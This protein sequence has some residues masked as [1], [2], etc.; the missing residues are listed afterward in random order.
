MLIRF[1]S[2]GFPALTTSRV[3]FL[4]DPARYRVCIGIQHMLLGASGGCCCPQPCSDQAILS[5]S[6]DRLRLIL[7][8]ISNAE[9]KYCP[10]TIMK[11]IV[12]SYENSKL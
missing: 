1:K 4:L 6:E 5:C 2:G 9:G 3:S 10:L 8:P 7:G 12:Y 11:Y